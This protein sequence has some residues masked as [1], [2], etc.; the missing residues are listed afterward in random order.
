MEVNGPV[1]RKQVLPVRFRLNLLESVRVALESIWANKLRSGLTMLGIIIGVA[2]V[3][4]VVAIGQGGKN[5]IMAELEK[6]GSN[7]FVVYAMSMSNE[8]ITPEERIT[9][10]DAQAILNYIPSVKAVAP[11]AYEFAEVETRKITVQTMVVGTTADYTEIR[12]LPLK[13][14]RFFNEQDTRSA[15]RLAVIDER[16]AETLF[17]RS[18]AALGKKVMLKKVPV[19]VVGII[20]EQQSMF[21]GGGS[22]IYIPIS[23]WQ[24]LFNTNRVDQLEASAI[25]KD[26]VEESIDKTLKLLHRRHKNTDRYRAFNMEKEMEAANKA[27]GIMTTIISAIAGISLVV[28]GI[29]VMNIMLVSV[30]E[31]TRE[32]GVRMAL[33]ARRKDVLIQ[34]LIEAIVISTVGGIIGMILGLGGSLLMALALK[35]PPFFSWTPVILAFTFS[36]VIGIFFGIYPAN[37]AARLDPI[38]ALRYE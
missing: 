26:Q 33:G 3:C 22:Q 30:T 16:L 21:G 36:A 18:E 11:S 17:G 4:L 9:V 24:N 6:M 1:G 15:R 2:A 5:Q 7:L 19:V 28:G 34:F 38:E 14:G 25:S 23:F 27:M 13:S 35:I 10:E 31:R 32:I 8:T 12:A 20:K 37:K 29:G